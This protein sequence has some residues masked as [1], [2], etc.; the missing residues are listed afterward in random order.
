MVLAFI[1]D[2]IG[3]EMGSP[4]LNLADHCRDVNNCPEVGN[5]IEFCQSQGIKVLISM[6]GAVGPYRH[7]KWRSDTLAWWMWNKFLG[8]TDRTLGRP[9]GEVILDGIDFDAEATNG[10]GYDKLVHEIRKLFKLYYPPRNFMITAAPQCP[11][12]DYYKNNAMYNILHPRQQYSDA[13]P[14]LIFIQF[15]NNLCSVSQLGQDQTVLSTGFNF[16]VWNN[17][18]EQNTQATKIYLGILGN[19]GHHDSGYLEFEKLVKI[20]DQVHQYS[21]FG[22]VMIWDALHAYTNPV[23]NGDQYGQAI[24]KY[25]D[26]LTKPPSMIRLDE[27][28]PLLLPVNDQNNNS[29]NNN[30]SYNNDDDTGISMITPFSCNQGQGFVLLN[31]ILLRHL[32][33]HFA[34]TSH[35]WRL[36]DKSFTMED[37]DSSLRMGSYLCFGPY[38]NEG[39]GLKYIYNNT[40][41]LV[42]PHQLNQLLSSTTSKFK[43][44][45]CE[46]I[47]EQ[48]N[49]N[50]DIY[51][52]DDHLLNIKLPEDFSSIILPQLIGYEKDENGN[53]IHPATLRQKHHHLQKQQQQQQHHHN[54]QFIPTREGWLPVSRFIGNESNRGTLV[55]TTNITAASLVQVNSSKSDQSPLTQDCQEQRSWVPNLHMHRPRFKRCHPRHTIIL[56][57]QYCT[58]TSTTTINV[59]SPKE[60]KTSSS[61]TMKGNIITAIDTTATLSTLIEKKDDPSTIIPNS[62]ET[63][64][65]VKKNIQKEKKIKRP[66]IDNKQQQG[67]KRYSV[68]T[69]ASTYADISNGSMIPRRP[70][71]SSSSSCTS[72]GNS[73]MIR[74]KTKVHQKRKQTIGSRIPVRAQ[75]MKV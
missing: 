55:D 52:K 22:G 66:Y 11:D 70:R 38:E 7:Q 43:R 65:M 6:G 25:L 23:F 24:L 48:T 51:V 20:L 67:L 63:M 16:D 13:Y 18:A 21:R 39:Y 42:D 41:A 1:Y 54:H 74:Q 50:N 60:K 2:F 14:D 26:Q 17:W 58:N 64:V 61:G 9:F 15:Y 44:G 69:S 49:S 3:G 68:I 27:T 72:S 33:K 75:T 46:D 36:I 71:S 32:L 62:E 4:V 30:N 34:L 73:M 53:T 12:L 57:D 40:L 37:L 10:E 45:A 8:G 29:T 31:S 5:D 35:Q 56:V 59:A 47:K 19:Q 28:T